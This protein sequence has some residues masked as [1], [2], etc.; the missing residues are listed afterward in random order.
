MARKNSPAPRDVTVFLAVSREEARQRVTAR[1]AKGEELKSRPIR[2]RQELNE[3]EAEYLNWTEYNGEM[4][5]RIYTSPQLADEY[6]RS[7]AIAFIGSVQRFDEEI[8]DLHESIDRKC[9]RLASIEERIELVPLAP[10]VGDDRPP[11]KAIAGV[12]NDKVFV[13]HG[14]DEAVREAVARFIHKLGLVPV[15]LHEQVN[16]GLTIVEKLERHGDVG[17]AI[18]LLTPDDVGGTNPESLQPRARQNVVLELGYFVGRLGRN[19]VC[20]IHRGTV[21]LPSDYVGVVYVPFDSAG[22]WSIQLAKEL[23]AAGFEIDTDWP[24]KS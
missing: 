21:E 7:P 19:H 18:I 3:A 1:I 10:N 22:G 14:H 12:A 17:Y 11:A 16:Q 15:I 8:R 4:L 13:V 5:R 9:R 6:D 23:R 2:D 20:A 24:Y